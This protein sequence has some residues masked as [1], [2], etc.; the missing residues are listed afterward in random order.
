LV[1]TRKLTVFILVL[2]IAGIVA[3]IVNQT[4]PGAGYASQNALA[5]ALIAF[6]VLTLVSYSFIRG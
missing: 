2:I 4:A 6:T 3:V 5:F 1:P